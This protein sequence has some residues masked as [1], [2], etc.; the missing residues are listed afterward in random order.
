MKNF[1]RKVLFTL[2]LLSIKI[3]RRKPF[4]VYVNLVIN[5]RCN[6][7]CVYCFGNYHNRTD[8]EYSFEQIKNIVDELKKLGT[9]YILL[10][11][12]E[13]LL[14]ADLGKIIRYINAKGII[15]AIVTNGTF[16]EKISQIPELKLLDYICFSLDGTKQD[17]D[18]QRGEGV[19]DKVMKSIGEVKK[20]YPK[21]KTRLNSI[22]TKNTAGTF[23][24]FL[25]FAWAN[26][27]ET[28][29]NNMFKESPL[30][31]DKNQF[32][33]VIDFVYSAKK[34]RFPVVSSAHTIK[35]LRDWGFDNMWVTKKD[36]PSGI[37]CQYGY[38]QYIIDA[39]GDVYPCNA[40]QGIFKPKN[41]FSDG[42]KK[43]LDWCAAK[44]CYTC[45]NS[46]MMDTSEIINLNFKVIFERVA[47]ELKQLWR[48]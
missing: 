4:P 23:E 22:V 19:F 15:T 12:G 8:K 35:Y 9:R 31:P 7:N 11:G 30:A 36:F 10:Q 47:L 41:I 28:Q 45:A 2:S 26:K 37:K 13:P 48:K 38:Y 3:L 6:L 16:P 32:K 34:L 17:N 43:A 24:E 1:L 42:L 20:Y 18:D 33:K 14:R 44:P 21:L 29:V 40:L 39:N 25:K 5:S 27:L 46:G